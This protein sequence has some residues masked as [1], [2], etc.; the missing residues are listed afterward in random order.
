[1]APDT[2]CLFTSR[3]GLRLLLGVFRIIGIKVIAEQ[4]KARP[5]MSKKQ[6]FH[7]YRRGTKHRK[8]GYC[9]WCDD[10]KRGQS[11]DAVCLQQD[12]G[13]MLRSAGLSL[14]QEPDYATVDKTMICDIFRD[15][16]DK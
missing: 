14:I 6:K 9:F 16:N 3:F 8:C 7:N 15:M 4:K 1:M 13:P 12:I 2:C 11:S 10:T 5:T